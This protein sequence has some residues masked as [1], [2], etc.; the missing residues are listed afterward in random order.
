MRVQLIKPM[1]VNHLNVK[2]KKK[3][4]LYA[5]FLRLKTTLPYAKCFWHLLSIPGGQ[6]H[7][8]KNKQVRKF[9]SEQTPFLCPVVLNSNCLPYFPET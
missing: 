7:V 2:K 4:T 6:G 8:Q 3:K 5:T 9:S 1:C